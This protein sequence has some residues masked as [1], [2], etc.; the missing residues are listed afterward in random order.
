[1][2][3]LGGRPSMGKSA[4]ALS[5]ALGAARAGRGVIFASLEMPTAGVALRAITEHLARKGRRVAYRDARLG[6]L[7]E[8]E[9]RAFCEAAVE[10]EGL[11]IAM[12]APSIRSID[13]LQSAIRRGAR[14]LEAKGAPLGLVVFDYMQ[15]ADAPG[16]DAVE[17][18]GAISKA[19]KATAQRFDVPVIALSQLSRQVEQRDDKRPMLSDLR[20]SG[21]IE[22]DADV[23]LFCYREEYYLERQRPVEGKKNYAQDL[24]AWDAAMEAARGKVEIII[25]KQRM[26]GVATVELRADLATNAIGIEALAPHRAP[27]QEGFL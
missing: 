9:M 4:V 19:L 12:T 26:G 23:I 25:A 10:L 21:Q 13:A 27:A 7:G 18:V 16:R 11:P 5:I 15:L 2:V 1:M 22:Q 17:R 6:R 3:V 8:A 14:M 24:V 20:E